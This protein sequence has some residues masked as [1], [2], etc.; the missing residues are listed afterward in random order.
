MNQTSNFINFIRMAQASLNNLPEKV[1]PDKETTSNQPMATT[2]LK[3]PPLCLLQVTFGPEEPTQVQ[4]TFRQ[5]EPN[6]L[7]TKH[8]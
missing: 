1:T 8:K 3:L 5:Q 4:T 6:Q 2:K 7:H